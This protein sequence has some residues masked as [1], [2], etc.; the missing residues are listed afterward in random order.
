M[1][2]TR[3]FQ[4]TVKNRATADVEFRNGLLTEALNAV[5][6]GEWEVAKILLRDYINATE[7]FA[8]VGA[9][10]DKSPKNLMR[11]LSTGGNPSGSNLCLLIHHLQRKAGLSF[12]VVSFSKVGTRTKSHANRAIAKRSAPV[13]K[14][15]K[16]PKS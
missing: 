3:E 6:R 9:A 5:I 16:F 8:S 15:A 11:M 1:P 12:Q 10:I 13:R 7:G 4:E 14:P 2:L